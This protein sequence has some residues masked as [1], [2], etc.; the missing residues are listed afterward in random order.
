[1]SRLIAQQIQPGNLLR[2]ALFVVESRHGLHRF[3]S[4]LPFRRTAQQIECDIRKALDNQ[5]R[6]PH[7]LR[8]QALV[9]SIFA[10]LAA[11]VSVRFLMKFFETRNLMPFAIY[12]LVFGAASVIRFAR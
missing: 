11:Y 10:G 6:C 2:T 3:K 8:G 12:C 4:G 7:S 1:M 9:G 5:S